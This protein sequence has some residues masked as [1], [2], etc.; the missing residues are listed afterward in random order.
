[1]SNVFDPRPRLLLLL[2]PLAGA[3]L[4]GGRGPGLVATALSVA[5]AIGLAVDRGIAPAD[6]AVESLALAGLGLGAVWLAGRAAALRQQALE[7]SADLSAERAFLQSVLDTVPDAIMVIDDHGILR[8]FSPAAER[9]FGYAEREVTGQNVS[10]LMPSPHRQNHDGYLAKYRATGERHIIGIGRVVAGKRRDGTTFPLELSVGEINGPGGR[11]FTG[12]I[13]DLTERQAAEARLQELQSELT[14]ISRLSA[15]GEMASTLAHELNQPL[16]ALANYLRGARRL[17]D[18][19]LD[20]L[21]MVTGAL[22]KAA[23]QALRA[24]DI[25][26]RLRDFVARGEEQRA[27]EPVTKLVEEASALA[28]VGAKEQG[29]RVSFRL[30]P[31]AP[32][33]LVDRVQIQQVLVNLI[34]NAIDAMAQSPTRELVVATRLVEGDM[35]EISVSDTGPGLEPAIAANLFQP[36]QTTKAQGMG[37]GLSIC[38]TIIEAHGGRI[39]VD[40]PAGGGATFRFTVPSS[41]AGDDRQ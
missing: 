5:A 24:G 17:L 4:V 41:V 23:E 18:R 28:L 22:D 16:S 14:H 38:R 27:I 20:D 25:I 13:R 15:M 2:P 21:S 9:L 6:A 37:L 39:G 30:D 19:P 32:S 8:S 40:P 35:V 7:R 29:I 12:F 1:M 31:R 36:F 34:R 3:V 26:R 10:I 33:A 11:F